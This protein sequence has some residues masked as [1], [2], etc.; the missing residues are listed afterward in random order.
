MGIWSH[1]FLKI[2]HFTNEWTD[3]WGYLKTPRTQWMTESAF[4]S[5]HSGS[6]ISC[7]SHCILLLTLQRKEKHC[8]FVMRELL[9]TESAITKSYFKNS[10]L[11]HKDLWSSPVKYYAKFSKPLRVPGPSLK[12]SGLV[13]SHWALSRHWQITWNWEGQIPPQN[14]PALYPR[15]SCTISIFCMP[16]SSKCFH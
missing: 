2:P 7:L 11:L 5:W 3:W 16:W 15:R 4:E 9:E 6:R 13:Y 8:N 1:W 12:G 14:P 10:T